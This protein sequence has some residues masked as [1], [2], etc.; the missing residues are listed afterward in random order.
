M[1]SKTRK[2]YEK[3][4]VTKVETAEEI[5]G[6]AMACCALNGSPT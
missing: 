3:P 6:L 5:S 4:S 1:Q 2:V